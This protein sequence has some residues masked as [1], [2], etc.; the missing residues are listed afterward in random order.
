MYTSILDFKNAYTTTFLLFYSK[1]TFLSCKNVFVRHILLTANTKGT[2]TLPSTSAPSS[3]A[4]VS[5]MLLATDRTTSLL[6]SSSS[7]TAQTPLQ[8]STTASEPV[9][10]TSSKSSFIPSTTTTT[11]SEPATTPSSAVTQATTEKT[12][13]PSHMAY[14][15][16]SNGTAVNPITTYFRTTVNMSLPSVT[17]PTFKTTSLFPRSQAV[18]SQTFGTTAKLTS[19]RPPS[20]LSTSPKTSFTS[21][22]L[23]PPFTTGSDT[24]PT[25]IEPPIVVNTPPPETNSKFPGTK[26]FRIDFTIYN[27]NLS[28]DL[29]NSTSPLYQEY[30]ENITHLLENLFDD[31]LNVSE[32]QC[33]IFNFSNGPLRV[34]SQCYIKDT[35]MI[36]ASN[37]EAAFVSG[38]NQRNNLGD[39]LLRQP[40]ESTMSSPTTSPTSTFATPLTQI[41]RTLFIK[42]TVVNHTFSPE[43]DN[44]SSPL[45]KEYTSSISKELEDLFKKEVG[46]ETQ[47]CTVARYW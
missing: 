44:K 26:A 16:S 37:V 41:M 4:A 20:L 6:T 15:P 42:F 19:T 45:Y 25:I 3:S 9:G 34:Q 5:N 23:T 24:R 13:Q 38:T 10:Q 43:M 29:E 2:T 47:N 17:S 14:T 27:H 21:E 39:Y 11:T 36:N 35:G 31:Q 28:T 46:S 8:A 18:E 1:L 22:M 32:T 30:Q 12:T 40:E 33:E 7:S